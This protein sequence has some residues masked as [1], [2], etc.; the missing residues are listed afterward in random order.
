MTVKQKT[1]S[2][3]IET[4]NVVACE[5]F[6][7]IEF[8]DVI[9]ESIINLDGDPEEVVEVLRS[10]NQLKC[11]LRSISTSALNFDED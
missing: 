8:V 2:Q 5:K 7:C 1:K 6:D 11:D 4:L 3:L 9:I 10:M